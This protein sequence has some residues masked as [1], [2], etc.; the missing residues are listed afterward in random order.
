M[1]AHERG[2]M[3]KAMGVLISLLAAPRDYR[4][5]ETLRSEH[6][7]EDP[8]AI[9]TSKAR[10]EQSAGIPSEGEQEK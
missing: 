9:A 5:L 7:T 2:G 10:A 4:M 1:L 6:L 8:A 3:P